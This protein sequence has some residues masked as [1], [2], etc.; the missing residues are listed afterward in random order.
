MNGT[1]KQERA[2]RKIRPEWLDGRYL[3]TVDLREPLQLEWLIDA[4]R[5]AELPELEAFAEEA[6]ATQL[7]INAKRE[8]ESDV[9]MAELMKHHS[10]SPIRT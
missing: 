4:A 9:R 3:E 10:S 2:F 7:A 8:A 5:A 6:L 1:S